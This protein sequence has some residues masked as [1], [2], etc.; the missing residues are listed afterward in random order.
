M[1]A[2]KKVC[3]SNI[4]MHK[5][6]KQ[7]QATVAQRIARKIGLPQVP[8]RI[9]FSTRRGNEVIYENPDARAVGRKKYYSK[10]NVE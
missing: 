1:G 9:G 8:K 10:E 2:N 6:L 5:T 7:K 3:G 4:S